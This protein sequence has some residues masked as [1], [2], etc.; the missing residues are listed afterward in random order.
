MRGGLL[1]V[2][3][4]NPASSAAMMN[5]CRSACG[6]LAA[7]PGAAARPAHDPPAPVTGQEDRSFAALAGD[8][9]DRTRAVRGASGMAAG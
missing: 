3:Q 7:H 1:H 2:R 8:Q 6:R 4:R 9:V 5:A